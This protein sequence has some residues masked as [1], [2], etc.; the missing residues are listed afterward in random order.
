MHVAHRDGCDG[1]EEEQA[2]EQAID[3]AHWI[4]DYSDWRATP[5]R[6]GSDA[7][8][9]RYGTANGTTYVRGSAIWFNVA[10]CSRPRTLEFLRGVIERIVL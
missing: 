1:K 6:M 4:N 5:I 7:L 2:T 8:R 3:H 9:L 10:L